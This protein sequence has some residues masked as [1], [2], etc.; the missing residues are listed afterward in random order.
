M[1]VI[2]WHYRLNR[3]NAVADY[4]TSTGTTADIVRTIGRGP[5]D[6]IAS[7]ETREGREQNRRVDI[8]VVA[9]V[10]A[11]D[12]MLFPGV[13]L[14]KRD[15]A[16]LNDQGAVEACDLYRNYWTYRRQVGS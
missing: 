11:L 12:Q 13:V 14:F 8:T 9:E 16:D 5:N 10:R 2:T 15:K 1:K 3:A 7:N 4:L 6:P